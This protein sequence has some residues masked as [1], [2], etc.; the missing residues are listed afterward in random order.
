MFHPTA[1]TASAWPF[2]ISCNLLGLPLAAREAA[3]KITALHA[4][5]LRMFASVPDWLLA[6]KHG[7]I[8]ICGYPHAY[9]WRFSVG[10]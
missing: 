9:A 10:A 1:G 2:G 5:W 7:V 6:T 3:V 4:F 8:N